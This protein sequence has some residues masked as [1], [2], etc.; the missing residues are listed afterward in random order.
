MPLSE[1]TVAAEGP[2]RAR[3]TGIASSRFGLP[4][5][6]VIGFLFGVGAYVALLL[7]T[8]LDPQ[9][10]NLEAL[11]VAPVLVLLT[12]PMAVRL[13]R[14]DDDPGILLVLLIAVAAV[15]QSRILAA[16]GTTDT[17]ALRGPRG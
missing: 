1:R 14:A 10:D 15:F 13:A 2:A 6:L 8:L 17:S 11:V 12:A 9:P 7:V 16:F 3:D 4:G 5:W